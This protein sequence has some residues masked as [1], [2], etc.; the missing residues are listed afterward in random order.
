MLRAVALLAI[1]LASLPALAQSGGPPISS[2]LRL[3]PDA[4]I[5]GL[6]RLLRD[7]IHA[8]VLPDGSHIPRESPAERAQLLLPRDVERRAL[9]AGMVSGVA[10]W[11]GVDSRGHYAAMM[12]WE[13]GAQRWSDKQLGYIDGLHG[14]ARH[15]II[16]ARDDRRCDPG[17]KA[18]I[19]DGLQDRIRQ[20]RAATP[21]R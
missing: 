10:E 12:D 18:S 1:S 20:Y 8:Y 11:C 13:R 6:I 21:P 17:H 14:S 19:A 16:R 2:M 15:A 5:D 7:N 3:F 9:D 4:Q